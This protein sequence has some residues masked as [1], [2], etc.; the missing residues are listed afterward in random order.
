ME[1]R[2]RDGQLRLLRGSVTVR[3]ACAYRGQSGRC[4]RWTQ[5]L[6]Q[7]RL[8]ALR[9][10][11]IVYGDVGIIGILVDLALRRI[12][13]IWRTG[14]GGEWGGQMGSGLE[15]NCGTTNPRR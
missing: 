4:R 11:T 5:Q 13:V 6:C 2:K 8:H 15:S 12:L 14:G 9:R 10:S 3:S 7:R 1:V